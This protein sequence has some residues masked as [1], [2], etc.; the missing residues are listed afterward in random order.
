ME[1]EKLSGAYWE[2]R[3]QKG[4]TGWDIGEISTPLLEYFNSLHNKSIR[5]L[6]P[7][8]GN[9]Y[10]A[11]YLYSKGFSNVY[12]LD[13]AQ[14]PL[15]YF[16]K[17]NPD[18]PEAH[19]LHQD[20]FEHRGNYD[21]IIEQTFFCAIDPILRKKYVAHTSSLLVH[22]GNLAG[23]LFDCQFDKEG[24]PFGGSKDEY[25]NLF[26]PH[27]NIEKLEPC[28]NSISPRSGKELFIKA[29]KL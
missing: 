18:F 8:C 21:L 24:P 25:T 10:E 6:I 13:F 23:L 11:A 28:R 22:S 29:T 15:Q 3:Y 19:L 7:G 9:A 12:L 2:S 5:I 16:K 1:N 14:S 17:T 27:F 4:E 26:Q 20:F